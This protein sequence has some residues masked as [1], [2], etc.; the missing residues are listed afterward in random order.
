[1]ALLEG[2]H[3]DPSLLGLAGV[4][5]SHIRWMTSFRMSNMS[6][7]SDNISKFCHLTGVQTLQGKIVRVFVRAPE[8][9]DFGVCFG[10]DFCKSLGSGL[11]II[12]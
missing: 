10:K 7:G 11:L 1:L 6:D 2:R 5:D 9:L 8:K 12:R 4:K 3:P